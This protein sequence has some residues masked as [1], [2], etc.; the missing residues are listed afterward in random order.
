[1]NTDAI[2][3]EISGALSTAKTNAAFFKTWNSSDHD[4]RLYRGFKGAGLM[5]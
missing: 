2:V 1:M 4:G 3:K 5:R